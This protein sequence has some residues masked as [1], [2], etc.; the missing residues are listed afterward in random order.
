MN[1]KE[2]RVYDDIFSKDNFKKEYLSLAKEYHPDINHSEEAERL[3]FKLNMFYQEAKQH[4]ENDSWGESKHSIIIQKSNKKMQLKYRYSYSTE[5]GNAYA[6]DKI[7]VFSFNQK[8]YYDNYINSVNKITYKDNRQKEYFEKFVPK[9]IDNFE[10]KDNIFYVVL[11]KDADE[12]PLMLVKEIFKQKEHAAWVL[13]RLLN[14]C[15]LFWMNRFVHNG[16]CI[17][18]CYVNLAKHGICLYGGWQF[19]TEAGEKMI[20]TSKEIFNI[21]PPLIKD[22]KIS[23]YLTDV[24]C[25]KFIIRSLLQANTFNQL[26][27]TCGY[28]MAEF[29]L[30][31]QTKTG[32]SNYGILLNEIEMDLLDE[33]KEWENVRDKTFPNK[34]FIKINDVDPY[35]GL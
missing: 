9:I 17:N 21:L 19:G 4:F 28:D 35:I 2:A 14:L 18:N 33:L 3:M 29:L 8:K 11:E 16:I 25:S 22:E 26:N 24:E 15:V 27:K 32:S 10:S 6:G 20:G 5:V 1:L 13:T 7:L 12:Y 23:N 30:H 34:E 31:T